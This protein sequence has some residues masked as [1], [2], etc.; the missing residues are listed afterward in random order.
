MDL[1]SKLDEQAKQFEPKK[2]ERIVYQQ[3]QQ[4]NG[5]VEYVQPKKQN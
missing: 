2:T 4:I 1:Q 5:R 3:P